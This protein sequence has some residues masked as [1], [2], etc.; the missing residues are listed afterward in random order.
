[1]SDGQMIDS[2]FSRCIVTS[3]PEPPCTESTDEWDEVMLYGG[4]SF[5]GED[6]YEEMVFCAC[7]CED[8]V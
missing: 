7:R 5:G 8:I 6:G 4:G 2:V 1:M 3:R